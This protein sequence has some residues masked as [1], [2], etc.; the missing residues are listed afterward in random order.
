MLP[1]N[2][3]VE[4]QF[5]MQ[6]ATFNKFAIMHKLFACWGTPAGGGEGEVSGNKQDS[7]ISEVTVRWVLCAR[8][9]DEDSSLQ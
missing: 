2:F 3:N 9:S 7:R 6:C 5:I 8:R 4:T 1:F